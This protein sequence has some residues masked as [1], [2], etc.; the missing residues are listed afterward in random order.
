MK[1]KDVMSKK[2]IVCKENNIYKGANLMKKYDIGF[3][4]IVSEK[5]ILGIVTDRDIV[6][7]SI[8]NHDDT[9]NVIHDIKYI[10]EG[11][12][13]E[14]ACEIMKENKVKRL[15]VAN[16][17]KVAG[18]ISLSDIV[19]HIDN[20]TFVNTFKAIYEIDKNEHDYDVEIDEFYL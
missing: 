7:N 8:Y 1:V 13:L 5:K 10:D 15:L 16:E 2:L 18:V 11:A 3:L 6:V 17:N 14:Q 9:F 20:D 4:P 12:T 19:S